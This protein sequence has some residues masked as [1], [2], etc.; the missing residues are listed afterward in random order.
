MANNNY[1]KLHN[2][3]LPYS[4]D[5]RRYQHHIAFITV[6]LNINEG[7][8]GFETKFHDNMAYGNYKQIL[9]TCSLKLMACTVSIYKK[10]LSDFKINF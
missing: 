1:C 9:K 5:I 10:E 6:Y 2:S 8:K 4:E 7:Q 3:L